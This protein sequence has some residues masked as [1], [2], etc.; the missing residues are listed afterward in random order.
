MSESQN[1]VMIPHIK[2]DAI[3]EVKMGA[4]FIS[5]IQY[6][7]NYLME[8]HGEELKALEAKQGKEENLT[9]W[10]NA[11]VTMSMLLQEVLKI[12][13]E[14]NQ[15]EF[16]SLEDSMKEVITTPN[17]PLQDSNQPE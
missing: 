16:K 8:G 3:I 5:R 14:N 9:L 12:A 1:G 4:A 7:L 17:S 13:Q 6:T 10:E 11:V 15:V 2:K